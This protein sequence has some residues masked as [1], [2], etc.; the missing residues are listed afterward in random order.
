MKVRATKPYFHWNESEPEQVIPGMVGE[1]FGLVFE[2]NRWWAAVTWDKAICCGG[3][4]TDT[5]I[6]Y[7]AEW[8]E[9]VV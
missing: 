5:P 7:P 6:D 3:I 1:A 8:L 9:V 2:E 4:Y